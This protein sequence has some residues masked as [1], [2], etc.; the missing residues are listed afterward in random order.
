MLSLVSVCSL[1]H[2]A[3]SL[4]ASDPVDEFFIC[5]GEETLSLVDKV[6]VQS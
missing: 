6:T 4:K 3:A 5:L 1:M 2:L